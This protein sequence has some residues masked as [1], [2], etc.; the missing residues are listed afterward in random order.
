MVFIK[1]NFTHT[2]QEMKDIAK[3]RGGECLSDKYIGYL[4][5]LKWKCAKGHIWET[6]PSNILNNSWCQRCAF[7][8]KMLRIED[9]KRIA[10]NKNGKLLSRKYKGATY[11]YKW[12]CNKGHTWY[13][14]YPPIKFDNCWC[15]KCDTMKTIENCKTIAKLRNGRCINPENYINNRNKLKWECKNEHQWDAS[16]SHI[17]EG[18]WCPYCIENKSENKCREIFESIFKTNFYKTRFKEMR[19]QKPLELDGYSQLN[20]AFEYNGKQHYE[21]VPYIHKTKDKFIIQQKR[22]KIKYKWCKDNNI[23]LFIIPY[24]VKYNQLENYIIN[25]LE[26]K[27]LYPK[28]N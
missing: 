10:Q 18:R 1:G 16:P 25:L 19:K 15:P 4:K 20:I 9:L 2:I 27:Y 26:E 23:D 3:Q 17:Q 24:T 28:C 8:K 13:A 5:N 21:F 11:K 12:Q 22:D 7:D 14:V 6:N